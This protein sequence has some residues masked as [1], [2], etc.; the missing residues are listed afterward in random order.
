MKGPY[1][2]MHRSNFEVPTFMKKFVEIKKIMVKAWS[3]QRL[4]KLIP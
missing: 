2:F 4:Q 3:N 1:I